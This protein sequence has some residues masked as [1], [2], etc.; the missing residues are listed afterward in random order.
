MSASAVFEFDTKKDIR[1]VFKRLIEAWKPG[2]GARSLFL[3][4]QLDKKLQFE[5]NASDPETQ[6]ELEHFIKTVKPLSD[7]LAQSIAREYEQ[8]DSD[9]L[10]SS[11]ASNL[12]ESIQKL[13]RCTID[14]YFYSVADKKDFE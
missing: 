4:H 10:P 5:V 3:H 7:E 11:Q 12:D 6:K 14:Y 1:E 2:K 13:W 9:S 8:R